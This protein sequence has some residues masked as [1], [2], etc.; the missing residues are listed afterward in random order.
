MG[1]S[2]NKSLEKKQENLNLKIQDF[3]IKTER[4]KLDSNYLFRKLNEE[5]I[6]SYTK[7]IINSSREKIF[8]YIG[9]TYQKSDTIIIVETFIDLVSSYKFYIYTSSDKNI[10]L[11][12]EETDSSGIIQIKNKLVISEEVID[13]VLKGKLND[14]IK[15]N[16][17]KLMSPHR[18]YIISIF[19]K[20][21]K[22][23]YD[24]F[25]KMIL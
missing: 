6:G 24:F 14:F 21:I 22:H 12:Y 16:E 3:V 18:G 10:K 5:K 19:N 2:T 9:N 8:N 15:E 11:Y 25:Y 13:I 4:Q 1:C 20:N 17:K 23:D 7:Q